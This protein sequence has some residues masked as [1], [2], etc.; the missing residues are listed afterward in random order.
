[1]T[2][3]PLARAGHRQTTAPSAGARRTAFGVTA[4]LVLGVV[5]LSIVPYQLLLPKVR[6]SGAVHDEQSGL[7]IVGARVISGGVTATS[8][9]HGFFTFERASLAEP[10][11]VEA[12]GY[13]PARASA[14]PVRDVWVPLAPRVFSMAVRDAETGEPVAATAAVDEPAR[15]RVTG[16]GQV[17]VWPA[18]RETMVMLRAEGY[19]DL[20]VTY[21]G[22]VRAD[23][24]MQPR[25]TGGVIDG[26]TGRS[27]PNAFLSFEGGN[28]VADQEGRFELK[29]RPT[30]RVRV[31]APGYRRAEFEMGQQRAPIFAL[32][33]QVVKGV[34]LTY[35]AVGDRNL[36][37]GVL[38]L[39]ERTEVNA[40]VID[41]KGDRGLLSY[42]SGVPLAEQIGAN[43]EPTISNLEEFLGSL[44]QRGIYTI[45]RIVVFKDDRLGRNGSKIGFDV[46]IKDGRNGEPWIDGEG[47][48]WVDPSR[49]EVW[50]Y[51]I[52]LARE[53]AERGFDEIQ[54]DYIRFPT[55]PG[56]GRSVGGAIYSR[57]LDET[58]R[59]E[60]ITGFLRRA[61]QEVRT[62]GA[63]LGV[64]IFGYVVWNEGDTG[65]GQQLEALADVVDYLCPMIYPSTF[66]AGLPGL[67]NYPQVVA[68][69]YEV[70]HESMKLARQ[71]VEGRGAVLRPWLQYF[72]DYPW[73]TRRAYN[74]AEINA[75]KK[76]A[77][78][79]GSVG[80]MMWDP[81]NR[82]ARGGF[83]PK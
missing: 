33:P 27:V 34:Y 21:Q 73:Q 6:I 63:F 74:A 23:V 83:G 77:G 68:R 61:R 43:D 51:N 45:A 38:D 42:R 82:Y 70:I 2:T 54:F 52:A 56:S 59:I 60:A 18:R 11:V 30:G 9:E 46:A 41:V 20:E 16:P 26:A 47:L 29:E 25:L 48:A 67:M 31:L 50:E 69:P 3:S 36:R 28:L 72:D 32:E 13:L 4:A 17:D 76:A 65:I 75:Q 15:V 66:A 53:A 8:V 39:A 37:S 14:W 12:D 44:K 71:R 58:D 35:Y 10:L 57:F 5:V 64:D 22:E 81:A 80:W 79:A 24:R 78:D 1:M 7:P 40:L 49:T 55:D 62:A 19:R